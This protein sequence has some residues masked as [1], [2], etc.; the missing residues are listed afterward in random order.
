[1]LCWMLATL[2]LILLLKW[3]KY[4]EKGRIKSI[5]MQIIYIYRVFLP[6]LIQEGRVLV[7]EKNNKIV[8]LIVQVI[9]YLQYRPAPSAS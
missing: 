8:I 6:A 4:A 2:W 1:M 9:A 7:I 3:R 5:F